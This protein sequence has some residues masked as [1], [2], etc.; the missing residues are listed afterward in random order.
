MGRGAWYIPRDMAAPA[1]IIAPPP[2][3]SWADA[4]AEARDVKD[5]SLEERYALFEAACRLVFTVLE[6]SPD[7]DA[8]L[9]FQ[10]PLPP[11]TRELIEQARR[12]APA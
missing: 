1:R 12:Q 4:V 7:R 8:I 10:E 2:R 11:E 3:D 5:L 6:T 9:A